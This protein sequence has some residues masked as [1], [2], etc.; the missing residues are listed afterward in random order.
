MPRLRSDLLAGH[1]STENQSGVVRA[2]PLI[3]GVRVSRRE[4]SLICIIS[5]PPAPFLLDARWCH[6]F[7][8]R[9]PAV[10]CRR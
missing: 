3:G 4:T 2:Q 6:R 9:Q 1:A 8:H 7:V 5:F 10:F